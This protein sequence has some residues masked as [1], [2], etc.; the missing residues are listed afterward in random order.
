[1]KIS[2]IAMC[3]VLGFGSMAAHAQ[4]N[5][6][7]F[8]VVDIHVHSQA[9]PVTSDGPA[10]LTPQP[11]SVSIGSATTALLAYTRSLDEHWDVDV[12]IG[13]PPKY[14]VYGAGT[15]A[16]FGVIAT[17]KE[18]APT[19][20]LIYNFGNPKDKL[21]P[22]IGLGLNY[23]KFF[24]ATATRS[25]ELAAGGPSKITASDSTGLAGK[26]G[27]TYNL[28]DRWAV[29]GSAGYADVRTNLS[30]TTGSIH[31]SGE[32]NFRPVTYSLTLGY[33]F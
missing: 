16:S 11:A 7:R 10:F 21:R 25:G 20:F 18:A 1:M 28:S 3:A 26:V 32:V 5:M 29:I 24:D 31:R 30:V 2:Q 27:L 9:S 19:V 22:Y 33:R 6:V 23:T 17:V 4:Q 12:V 8:G 14:N 13:V 15:F